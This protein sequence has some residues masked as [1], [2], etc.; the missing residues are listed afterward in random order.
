VSWLVSTLR[1]AR[2]A[3]A[4]LY[5]LAVYAGVAAWLPWA[6][7]GGAAPAWAGALWLEHPFSSP[8]FLASVVLLFAST[9]A[10]TWGRR[11]RTLALLRGAL[12]E[13]SATLE[14]RG[15]RDP[16]A[17]LHTQSFR[18]EGPIL[19]RFGFAMWGGWIF[20]VGLLVLMAAV[21]VQQA[22]HDEASFELAV[23]EQ[24]RLSDP[25]AVFGRT[26]G[27]FAPA[28]PPGLAVGLLDF[29][30]YLHQRGYAP[31]RASR[32]SI[33][34]GGRPPITAA[35]DRADGVRVGGVTIYQ[36]IPSGLGLVLEVQ[37][38]GARSIHLREDGARAATA[39]VS[40]PNGEPVRFWVEAERAISDPAG[41]GLLSI[42]I[43]SRGRR[44]ALSPGTV[45]PFGDRA[46]RLQA[47]GRWAGFTYARSPGMPGVFAGFAI[48][49]VGTLLLVFPAA[50][51]RVDA[52]R[53]GRVVRV[54]GRGSAALLA[55]WERWAADGAEP[56]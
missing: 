31:D 50:V 33:A 9:L 53:E 24:V 29:D 54:F 16:V 4:V 3:R 11:P 1:T 28:R 18:G 39:A 15:D 40:A 19:R 2:F 43:E 46:A 26:T 49:L 35:V 48:I 45:F 20:H 44:T 13:S 51:A 5:F 41:T 14:A 6:R 30:P 38:M 22:F 47:V 36:A 37:G 8:A 34:E 21:A 56:R 25:D 52:A 55:R 32:L 12:P 10:C 27:I 17:F 7:G 42:S 23:R